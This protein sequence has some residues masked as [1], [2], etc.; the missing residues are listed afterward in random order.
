M[1]MFIQLLR[2]FAVLGVF[3]YHGI[4]YSDIFNHTKVLQK[5]TEINLLGISAVSIF[6]I[7]S[8]YIMAFLVNEKNA[9]VFFLRKRLI[10]IY[11]S[12][13]IACILA[14]IVQYVV[15]RV[16]NI[17]ANI[18]LL[19][20]LSLIPFKDDTINYYLSVEWSLIYEVAFYVLCSIFLSVSNKFIYLFVIWFIVLSLCF[21]IVPNFGIYTTLRNSIYTVYFAS[22]NFLFC[23][24]A[25]SYY[26]TTKIKV[27]ININPIILVLPYVCIVFVINAYSP[28][29]YIMNVY[30]IGFISIM[31]FISLTKNK[32]QINKR[33]VLIK[34]GDYSYGI[35]LSHAVLLN[36]YYRTNNDGIGTTICFLIVIFILSCFFGK[37]EFLFH[38]RIKG[39]LG[40]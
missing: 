8:G 14:I 32:Y 28:L 1:L 21:F 12:Y 27:N 18:N 2:A 4:V 30:L 36:A 19:K 24:G 31:L 9:D 39:F 17:H 3:V 29:S 23:F 5:F 38:N 33:N 35:Y 10:R 22:Y 25:F 13:F 40:C 15:F 11:P 37:L 16:I 20:S 7:I 34:I 6:F 26:L